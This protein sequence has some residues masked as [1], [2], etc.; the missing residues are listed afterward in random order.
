MKLL[1]Q[2]GKEAGRYKGLYVIAVLSTFAL[3]LV[4]LAAPKVLSAMTAVV[5]QGGAADPVREIGRL[6]ILL[7]GLYLLRVLFRFL[8]N[9]LAHK[10]AWNLVEEMRRRVYSHI[11]SLSMSF[12]HDKQT[13]DLMS[14]VVNDTANFELLY[15]H[16]IPEM[17]TNVVTVVG[18]TVVLLSINVQLTL[19]TCIPIPFILLGGWIFSTKVRPNFKISQRALAD[20]NAKLQDNFSG[21]HEIQAFDQ[22]DYE[23]GQIHARTRVFTKAMLHA[24]KLSAVFHPCVEFLSSVGTVIVVGVGGLLALQAQ[25][26]VSDIVAFLLYLSLFYTPVSGL[27]RLM[28]DAQNTFAGAER[29]MEILQTQPEIHDEPQAQ[30]ISS[31]QGAIAFEHVDFSYQE[32]SAVLQDIS[33]SCRPGQMVA[34]VGPTGVG[35]T[36]LTQL[37]PRF[38][39]P[40]RGRVL[41]DGKDVRT[42]TLKSLRAQIAPV[43]QDT[44]LFNGTIADNIRYACPE[45]G[46]QQV[47]EAARAARIHDDIMAMPNQYQTQVGER[48]LRLS[49]GQKQRIAIARAIL[50]QAPVIILDEATASVDM[51]TERRIQQAIGELAGKRTIVAIAHRLS[52]IRNADLILVLQQGRIVQRGTHQELLRQEGLYRRLYDA[53][54]KE[55]VPA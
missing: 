43:L 50:R 42:L 44:F 41:L 27:A 20:L 9:Y 24:L 23:N 22:E 54:S 6:T 38:Y 4:N 19:L 51:E 45:A 52:T 49:G 16:L 39:D 10:A 30:E 31:A 26:S 13:G 17:I 48:G 7:V 11:Q 35:K 1:W 12:F 5:E 3:T 14:R 28:E 34:L 32:G 33:F 36:T 53:Q 46:D 8:S 25:L 37:I 29:V 2:L 18:V 21:I 55:D 47:Q 15:A 40:T